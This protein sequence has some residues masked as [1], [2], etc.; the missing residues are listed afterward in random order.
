[1]VRRKR[2]YVALK[3][4]LIKTGLFYLKP[5]VKFI[6]QLPNFLRKPKRKAQNRFSSLRGLN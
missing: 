4:I 1:M 5:L 6:N 3:D 2:I